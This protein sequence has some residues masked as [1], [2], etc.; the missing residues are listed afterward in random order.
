MIRAY[1]TFVKEVGGC[2]ACSTRNR[3]WLSPVWEIKMGEVGH[4]NL[5]I[6]LCTDCLA[7]LKKQIT[8][9]SKRKS[10]TK[11]VPKLDSLPGYGDPCS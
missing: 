2:N 6:R 7:S 10:S 8:S 11:K 5:S 1:K 4:S 3:L 9:S